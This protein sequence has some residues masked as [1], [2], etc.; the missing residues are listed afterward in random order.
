MLPQVRKLPT[1]TWPD[2]G[3]GCLARRRRAG[4]DSAAN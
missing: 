1:F 2:T 4:V 3:V